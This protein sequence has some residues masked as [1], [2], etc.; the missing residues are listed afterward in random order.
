[1]FLMLLTETWLRNHLDAEIQIENYTVF[2]ADR[3]RPKKK[4]G[5]NSGGVEMYI[6]NDL[7]AMSE[8]VLEYSTGVIEA[9]VLK[10]RS[11]NMLVCLIYRQPNDAAGGNESTSAQ[12]IEL[13][14]A[15]TEEINSLS[16]PIPTL[17]IAGDLN[18]PHAEWPACEAGPGAS[19]DERRMIDMMREFAYQHFLLQI[20]SKPTHRAGNVLDV[21]LTN[22]SDLFPT[23]EV[24]PS[25]PI[26]SHHLVKCAMLTNGGN[27]HESYSRSEN[28]GFDAVNLYSD[29][30]DWQKIKTEISD[31]NWQFEF[32]D[33]S[34][35]EMLSLVIGTCEQL[36][37][38][39][40][41]KRK[42]KGSKRTA[43][44]RH[45]KIL[46][47]KRTKLRKQYLSVSSPTRS[48]SIQESLVQVERQLHESYK[49]QETYE[50]QKA[51]EAIKQNPKFFFAYARNRGVVK[52]QLARCKMKR[53]PA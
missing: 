48:A 1:M 38:T 50:E 20:V 15:L 51:V 47:R 3:N 2:R 41:P 34:P 43:P 28:T 18:L 31:I 21:I 49:E 27:S 7:A 17:V 13:L 42:K 26:S 29:K 36:V 35:D 52:H 8:I 19:V 45:R 53:G 14:Q 16:S 9:L 23:V 46:M 30:T 5:R 33:K 12:F 32:Q 44:P 39:Y 37:L 11:L 25:Y 6:R 10:I 24:V 40:A 22:S 4:Y